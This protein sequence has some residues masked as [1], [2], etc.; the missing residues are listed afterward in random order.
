MNGDGGYWKVP[1]VIYK[2]AGSNINLDN[3]KYILMIANTDPVNT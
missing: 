1:Q 2:L 3:D